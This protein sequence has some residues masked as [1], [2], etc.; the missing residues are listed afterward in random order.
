M[1]LWSDWNADLLD[2]EKRHNDGS[3][4][5]FL[6]L[7]LEDLLDPN[8][9]YQQMSRVADFVG[10]VK[11]EQ[12]ICCLAKEGVKDMGSHGGGIKD[13]TK[14]YGKWHDP[15]KNNKELSDA[16]HTEGKKGLTAFGY[17]TLDEGGGRRPWMDATGGGFVCDASVRC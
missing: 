12:Q 15:L 8:E 9:R 4:F 14:R 1:Q 16:I 3:T 17:E 13:V 10:S 11:S 5:D 6:V 2:W 7:R